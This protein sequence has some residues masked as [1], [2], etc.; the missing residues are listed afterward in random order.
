VSVE[1]LSPIQSP[2]ASGPYQLLPALSDDEFADLKAD[3]ALRGVLIPVEI[4]AETGAILDGHH[5]VKAAEALNVPYQR[6]VRSFQSEGD[7]RAHALALNLARRHLTPEARGQVISALHQEGWSTRRISTATGLSQATVARSVRTRAG[8]ADDSPGPSSVVGADGK[9][10]PARRKRTPTVYVQGPGEQE[11]ARNALRALGSAVPERGVVD[12]RRAERLVREQRA[13]EARDH[14]VPGVG[15][16]TVLHSDFRALGDLVQPGSV[17]LILADPPYRAA[18]FRSGLWL[19]FAEHSGRWLR[20]GGLLIAYSGQMHLPEVLTTLGQHLTY[21][22]LFAALHETGSGM[23]QVR[24]RGIGCAW[25]PL[26]VFRAPGGDGL[27]P[28]T[29]D[30]VRGSGRE[31]DHHPWQQGESEAAQLIGAL[32]R[33]D[34]LVLDPF[35][36]S[37]TT[38]VVAARLGRRVVTCDVE[39]DA[40]AITRQ[41]LAEDSAE[42]DVDLA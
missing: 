22:W 20:P 31:K 19:D 42:R 15:Q 23:A 8:D 33:P 13:L 18:D 30:L 27:P 36:G 10:Y 1:G 40:V 29:V 41:R 3:I 17:D 24:Q 2:R 35:A 5:R 32:T 4:D 38:A 34:D 6:V 39:L 11:R 14:Q 9:R 21:W 16:A 7:K 25:K 37:G 28:W 12:L 26:V